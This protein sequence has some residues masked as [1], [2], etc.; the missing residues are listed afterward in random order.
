MSAERKIWSTPVLGEVS[1][2]N[3]LAG[4][5]DQPTV[6]LAGPSIGPNGAA[7]T[8]CGPLQAPLY[9][10]PIPAPAFFGPPVESDVRLKEDFFDGDALVG[11]AFDVADIPDI[12]TDREFAVGG[13]ALFH[14]LRAKAGVLP[15]DGDHRYI[16]RRKDV[17]GHHQNG[18][19]AEEQHHGR[20][21]VEGMRKPQGESDKAHFN[22]FP[23]TTRA[24][25]SD[26]GAYD[27]DG[28]GN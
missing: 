24:H 7:E 1:V 10:P 14:L 9:G 8:S 4:S 20:Q 25:S 6:I 17:L 2:R 12:R 19:A 23:S 21:Y 3:A 26:F 22:R 5:S 16:D 15:N 28:C 11:L 13:D 18:A 27:I